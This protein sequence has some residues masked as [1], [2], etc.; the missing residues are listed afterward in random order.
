MNFSINIIDNININSGTATVTSVKP[1][2]LVTSTKNENLTSE[3]KVYNISGSTSSKNRIIIAKIVVTPGTNKR[4]IKIPSFSN[5]NLKLKLK[6]ATTSK[7]ASGHS[8]TSYYE[9]D[10]CYYNT[11]SINKESDVSVDLI[12]ND[13][14]MPTRGGGVKT[15]TQ[16][17][18]NGTS[19]GKNG[20]T[21][22]ITI[23]G[24]PGSEA[25]VCIKDGDGR[26]ILRN[27][28]T[29]IYSSDNSVSAAHQFKIDSSG[30]YSFKQVFPGTVYLP[31]KVN[32]SMA[33][34]GTDKIIFDSL[35][36]VKV[37]DRVSLSTNNDGTVVHEVT[38]LDPDF[39]NANECTV[40][41][42][43]TAA[44]NTTVNFSRS[45]EY[46]LELKALDG[47]SLGPKISTTYP[48]YTWY[49]YLDPVVTIRVTPSNYKVSHFNGVSTGPLADGVSHDKKYSGTAFSTTDTY[50][51]FNY[52]LDVGGGQTF[53]GFTVPQ[54]S[55][56]FSDT[57]RPSKSD[58]TNSVPSKNGGTDLTINNFSAT[59]VGSQTITISGNLVINKFGN[60]DVIV[61]LDLDKVTTNSK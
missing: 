13:S 54:Y 34:S 22:N 29:D 18:T 52:T 28:N 41:P 25:T 14:I 43:L 11:V 57:E 16:I 1:Y 17:I 37:G 42:D 9:F 24:T 27:E 2:R 7:S 46:T 58:W 10:V 39:N 51:S 6:K 23:V 21:K 3:Q 8:Y 49:Q 61:E 44:D 4:F 31:T 30:S 38:V 59:S 47:T 56:T 33:A 32:G 55:T 48:T 19:L 60:K 50:V 12:Y 35:A 20:E 45:R 5:R 53:T 26:S 40:S 15:I 36:N